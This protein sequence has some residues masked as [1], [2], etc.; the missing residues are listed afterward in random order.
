[1]VQRSAG[2]VFREKRG[3]GGLGVG[4]GRRWRGGERRLCTTLEP[5]IWRDNRVTKF[6]QPL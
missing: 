3:S 5:K 1:M 4:P 6:A 2:V